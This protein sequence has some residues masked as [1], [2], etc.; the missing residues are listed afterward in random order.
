MYRKYM[1][2]VYKIHREEKRVDQN[3]FS[4]RDGRACA[5]SPSVP[6]RRRGFEGSILL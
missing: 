4:V 1:S 2:N 6:G 3:I 5:S